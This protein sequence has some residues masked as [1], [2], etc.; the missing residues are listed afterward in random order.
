MLPPQGNAAFSAPPCADYR[1]HWLKA[2]WAVRRHAVRKVVSHAATVART[3]AR[4][5][6]LSTSVVAHIL[7]QT[8]EWR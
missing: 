2:L 3:E 7:E 1:V 4:R 5:P 8:F 6:E